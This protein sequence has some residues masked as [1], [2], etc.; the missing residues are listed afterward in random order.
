MNWHERFNAHRMEALNRDTE[1]P[2]IT[3]LKG[4]HADLIISDFP[5]SKWNRVRMFDRKQRLKNKH[6]E[7]T[8]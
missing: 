1:I 7:S 4:F 5:V 8:N 6:N 2:P 3:E